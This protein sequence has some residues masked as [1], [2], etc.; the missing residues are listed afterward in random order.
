[1][2]GVSCALSAGYEARIAVRK[3]AAAL[4][5]TNLMSLFPPL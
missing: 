1:M 2:A 3:A 4:N 5:P